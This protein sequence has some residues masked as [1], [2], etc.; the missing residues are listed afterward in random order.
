MH[1]NSHSF[2][3]RGVQAGEPPRRD[4]RRLRAHLLGQRLGVVQGAQGGGT[5]LW[6]AASRWVAPDPRRRDQRS[7]MTHRS[8]LPAYDDA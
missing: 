3:L 4:D 8:W 2:V 5:R 1:Y 6:G 7:K